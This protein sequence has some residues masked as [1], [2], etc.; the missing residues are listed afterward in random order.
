VLFND[1]SLTYQK[2]FGERNLERHGG[3]REDIEFNISLEGL[4]LYNFFWI[5]RIVCLSALQ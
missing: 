3:E 5:S 2:K 1:I 4:G